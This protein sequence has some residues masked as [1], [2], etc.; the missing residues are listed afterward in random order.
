ML[1]LMYEGKSATT[2]NDCTRKSDEREVFVQRPYDGRVALE[3][4]D[5][6]EPRRGKGLVERPSTHRLY[7]TTS[8][9]KRGCTGEYVCCRC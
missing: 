9:W 8:E 1:R 2:D 4:E 6:P 3:G 5:G 7:A